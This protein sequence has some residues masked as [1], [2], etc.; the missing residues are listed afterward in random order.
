MNDQGNEKEL[1]G[2]G[3]D[4]SG[5]TPNPGSGKP[6][7]CRSQWWGYLA[8]GSAPWDPL[9]RSQLLGNLTTGCR[10]LRSPPG[11]P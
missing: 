1:C 6:N 5:H 4:L 3:P 9:P 8:G 10:G 7:L 2:P 11:L